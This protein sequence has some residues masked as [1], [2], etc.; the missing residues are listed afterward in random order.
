MRIHGKFHKTRKKRGRWKL[1]LAGLIPLAL[2]LLVDCQLRPVIQTMAAYQ[3]NAYAVQ[4]VNDAIYDQVSGLGVEYDD[5]IRLSINE[6]GDVTALQ[7]DMVRM[8]RLQSSITKE[9]IQEVVALQQENIQVPLGTMIGGP[10]FSGRGPDVEI[11]L[12]P[13][14]FVE[15]SITN[16]FDSAGINQTRHQIM[17]GVKMTMSAIIPGYSVSTDISTNVCLA[18]TVIVGLV[19]EAYT[20]V[21]DGTD[22]IVGMIEDYSAQE[23]VKNQ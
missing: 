5:L 17:L 3:A 14:S 11:R 19:P 18:E 9:I 8:N 6:A 21:G 2:M 23:R 15:T 20:L 12:V 13:A 1:I 16:V 10:F 22:P 7:T 4:A